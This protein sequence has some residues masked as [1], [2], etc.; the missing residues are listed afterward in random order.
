MKIKNILI[1]GGN[2]FVGSNLVKHLSRENDLNIF[3]ITKNSINLH[4]S[5][6][7]HYINIENLN[8]INIKET[9]PNNIDCIIH[10]AG[11]AHSKFSYK[12]YYESNYLLTKKIYDFAVSINVKKFIY[13]S[14]IK[15][16]GE[17]SKNNKPFKHNDKPNP[18]DNYAKT[19]YLAEQ[20]IFANSNNNETI[21]YIVR[22]PLILGPNVKGNIDLFL[23]ILKL[24]IPLPFKNI[25][26]KRSFLSIKNLNTFLQQLVFNY[27]GKKDI[28]LVS[29]GYSISTSDLFNKISY[30][31]KI[32]FYNFY[33]N[34]FIIYV[35]CNLFYLNK[36]YQKLF[37]SQEIDIEYTKKIV[38]WEPKEV[39]DQ[40]LESI[41]N[42]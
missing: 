17:I 5:N 9:L 1:T 30:F 19:K 26:N 7:I 25:N 29:D 23:K 18:F 34:K 4:N 36:Y 40:T 41:F 20:Y 42:E 10:L 27:K 11:K 16:N 24:K 2:G 8:L 22:P 21:V 15:V 12:E 6:A 31:S 32:K 37:C 3:V 13:L 35:F 39:L 38:D 33:L 14:T 28:F